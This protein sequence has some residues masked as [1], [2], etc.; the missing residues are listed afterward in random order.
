MNPKY[1]FRNKRK[2]TYP[3]LEYNIINTIYIVIVLGAIS[4]NKYIISWDLRLLYLII[5]KFINKI[6][7]YK[8]Y[9]K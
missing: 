7:Y 1:N 9:L 5:Y 8:F 6:N 4:S 2:W 3:S